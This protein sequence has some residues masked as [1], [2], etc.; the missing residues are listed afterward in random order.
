MPRL[1]LLEAV[2]SGNLTGVLKQLLFAHPEFSRLYRPKKPPRFAG[3]SDKQRRERAM[4]FLVI[5]RDEARVPA[6]FTRNRDRSSLSSSLN[7]TD[8]IRKVSAMASVFKPKGK[9]K[10]LISYRDEHGRLRKKTGTTDKKRSKQIAADLE[11]EVL[12]HKRGLIDPTTERIASNERKRVKDHLRD[13]E[14]ALQ[15]KG[16]TQKHVEL[17]LSRARRVADLAKLDRLSDLSPSRVQAAL[18][19]LR[20]QGMAL[21]TCNHH[22]AAIRAFSRWLWKEG[23]LS[24]D[25]LVGVSGFN[26]REDRRHDRR[27]LSIEELRRVIDAA[28]R[29]P[30][31]RR[32]SGHARA[33]CYRLA[34]ATG[35]RYSEIK[36]LTPASFGGTS[37]MIQAAYSKNGQTDTID[38]PPDVASDLA[39]WVKGRPKTE[40]VFPLPGRGAAMLRV[41]LEAAGLPYRDESGKVFDFHALRCQCATLMDQAGVAPR[42]V[43]KRMRHSTLELSGHYT[44]PRD[45]DLKQAALSLPSLRPD[46]DPND[47]SPTP[48]GGGLERGATLGATCDFGEAYNLF[49]DKDINKREHGIIIRVSGV[50]VPPP[51]LA[52]VPARHRQI[53][54]I[55]TICVDLALRSTGSYRASLRHNRPP[56]VP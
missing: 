48:G 27:T 14:A 15:A 41:D 35:L 23:R 43:Q 17:S 8:I 4:S 56:S 11:N 39:E 3:V 44:R 50:R 46:F 30:A 47:P 51:L 24:A 33:I 37:V 38:L 12:L 22:R 25:P 10:Y 32:M 1:Q 7:G 49:S 5:T 21:G 40:S 19:S 26:A 29:G 13:F 20:A 34:V 2:R 42:V 54:S 53:P 52:T 18:A 28:E 6:P 16:N 31:Y 9:S 45:A 36:S 55:S